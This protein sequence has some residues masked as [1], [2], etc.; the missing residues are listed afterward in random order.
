MK[1]SFIVVNTV[2]AIFLY[3]LSIWY[4]QQ[5]IQI[6]QINK[7]YISDT[8]KLK[9]VK[10]ID[11]WLNENV[12]STLMQIPKSA[13]TADIDL[14]HFF[15]TYAKEYSFQ[16]EKFVYKDE[17]AHFLDIKYSISRDNYNKL[18]KFMKQKYQGG[19]LFIK[20]FTIEKTLLNGELTVVQPY[21]VKNKKTIERDLEDVPQ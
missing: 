14:I 16:V 15:D 7:K 12:K 4:E 17:T 10:K 9:E 18:L 1:I 19:Y 6:Q 8:R 11:D 21:P 13:Q 20:S 3:F 2:L 5:D